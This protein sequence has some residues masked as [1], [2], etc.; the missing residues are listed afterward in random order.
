MFSNYLDSN[1]EAFAMRKKDYTEYLHLQC[2]RR[3][4]NPD[5]QYCWIANHERSKDCNVLIVRLLNNRNAKNGVVQAAVFARYTMCI[6]IFPSDTA[7]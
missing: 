7:A 5:T 3:I 1:I 6:C 2:A 4:T